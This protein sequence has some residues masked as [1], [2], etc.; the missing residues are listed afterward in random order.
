MTACQL[1]GAGKG[2]LSTVISSQLGFQTLV[3]R[4]VL[5]AARRGHD[6]GHNQQGSQDALARDRL[7]QPLSRTFYDGGASPLHR[8]QHVFPVVLA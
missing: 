5:F 2:I 6:A 7:A 3:D 8:V 1:T 4:K